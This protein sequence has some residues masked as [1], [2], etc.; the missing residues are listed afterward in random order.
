MNANNWQWKKKERLVEQL[1]F[2]NYKPKRF[3]SCYAKKPRISMKEDRYKIDLRIDPLI[4]L[5]QDQLN[6][7]MQNS[8]LGYTQMAT[9]GGLGGLGLGGLGG[10]GLSGLGGSASCL[11]L[12]GY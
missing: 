7:G 3:I 11:N 8:T 5:Y 4:A 9:A 6:R 2:F 10:G 12:G 1:K